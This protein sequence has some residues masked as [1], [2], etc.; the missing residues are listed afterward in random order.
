MLGTDL[1]CCCANVRGT[2]IGTGFYRN[3][4]CATGPDDAGRH[5][6]CVEATAE[7]LAFSKAVGNDLSTPLPQYMFPGVQPGDR[8]CLCA[9]RWKQAL[10]AGKAPRVFLESTHEKTLQHVALAQLMEHA[11]DREAATDAMAK[12]E[13]LRDALARTVRLDAGGPS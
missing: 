1:K 11:L 7:F 8:W 2:G 10:E 5:T 6:V 12:L 4:D 13:Q 9:S 3:G